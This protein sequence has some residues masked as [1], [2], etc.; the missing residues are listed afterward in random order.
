VQAD[1]IIYRLSVAFIQMLKVT[2]CCQCLLVVNVSI[3]GLHACRRPLDIGDLP[4]SSA[5][6]PIGDDR[7]REFRLF[8]IIRDL[9]MASKL[10][11]LGCALGWSRLK[12]VVL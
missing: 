10:I 3:L 1:I 4:D 6:S 2:A 5:E 9:L 11:S 12:P 8:I 7:Y